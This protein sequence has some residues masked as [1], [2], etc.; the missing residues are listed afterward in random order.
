MNTELF[1]KIIAG[2]I[3]CEK[4][5]EDDVAFAFL[6]INPVNPGHTV[7]IPKVWSSGLLDTDP[8]ILKQ[9]AVAIQRVA[10]A[11]KQATNCEGINIIQNDGQAAGQVI[12]HLHFHVIPRFLN[13]GYEVWHGKPY[14]TEMKWH[15][16][17]ASIRAKL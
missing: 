15:E 16:M 6:D 17:G 3:P 12:F 2:E 5:Y 1:K 11:L 8:E 7:V 13:D 9:L 10:H 4:I 14:E